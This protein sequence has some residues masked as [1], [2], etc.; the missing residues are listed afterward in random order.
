MAYWAKEVTTW[1]SCS[2]AGLQSSLVDA[3]ADRADAKERSADGLISQVLME[4]WVLVSETA[5]YGWVLSRKV[6]QRSGAL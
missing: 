6:G 2:A 5:S 4:G 1:L 3:T